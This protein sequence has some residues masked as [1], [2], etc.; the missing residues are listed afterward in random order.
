MVQN[1]SWDEDTLIQLTNGY[2]MASRRLEMLKANQQM[3]P[4]R[5]FPDDPLYYLEE[6]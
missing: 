1:K 5:K 3:F 2:L 4:D 6:E